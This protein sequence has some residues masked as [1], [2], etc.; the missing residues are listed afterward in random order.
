MTN[1]QISYYDTLMEGIDL[2]T[3]PRVQCLACECADDSGQCYHVDTHTGP[4]GIESTLRRTVTL[5]DD[6]GTWVKV[7]HLA[8]SIGVANTHDWQERSDEI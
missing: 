1:E 6:G 8:G 3:D 5:P 7:E 4:L 2:P